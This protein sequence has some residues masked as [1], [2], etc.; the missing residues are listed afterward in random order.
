MSLDLQAALEALRS[1]EES[2]R[3]ETVDRLGPLAAAPRRSPR[4]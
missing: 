4:C 3:R 1:G 2:L